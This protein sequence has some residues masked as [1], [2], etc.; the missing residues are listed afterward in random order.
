[1]DQRPDQL[2]ERD[3]WIEDRRAN[4]PRV[5][6]EVILV[7]AVEFDDE[8]ERIKADIEDTRVELGQTINEIQERLSPEHLMDQVKETV[9]EATIGKVER[10]ME[11]VG[12][13]IS[14]V[15]EPAMDAMGRA[16]E[17]LKETGSS[18]GSIVQQNPIPCALIGLGIGMFIVN[19]IRNADGRI[20]RS[21]AYQPEFEAGMAIPRHADRGRQYGG[22]YGEYA[23]ASRQYGGTARNAL[24][25]VK[26][27]AGEWTHDTAERV[28]HLGHQ[29]K[30]GA[31]RAGRGFQHLIQENPLAVGAAAVAVG[32][33]VGLALPSTRIEQEY[34]G[35]TSEKLVDKAQQ[36]A[37]DAM[38]KVKT[39]AQ[40]EQPGLNA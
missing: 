6:E 33:V 28:S 26:E 1:M 16:G 22:S 18:V 34:M 15:T 31:M 30:E 4:V 11:S 2:N 39:A 17:K 23:G 29:A 40:G 36:V 12:D 19:R 14:N 21:R 38:D 3:G 8:T 37:R 13:K 24:N 35:E 20:S 32:A 10:V 27:T 7:E 5:D 9:R 25:R